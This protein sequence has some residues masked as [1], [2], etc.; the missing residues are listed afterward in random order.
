V[1]FI[2]ID[3]IMTSR[4]LEPG[5]DV[6]ELAKHI[7]NSGLQFPVLIDR[8][9]NLIDGLRRIEAHRLLGRTQIEALE[10][11]NSLELMPHLRAVKQHGHLAINHQTYERKWA[12]YQSVMSLYG[13]TRSLLTRG[14]SSNLRGRGAKFSVTSDIAEVL[15]LSNP[16]L[17][18]FV[19]LFRMRD[20]PQLNQEKVETAIAMLENGELTVH[21]ALGRMRRGLIP[22][23]HVNNL[24][25]QRQA[26][27]SISAS[28]G[29]LGHVLN[30]MGRL[31]PRLSREEVEAH[32]D[33]MRQ[34]QT[35]L[36]RFVKTYTEE[37]KNR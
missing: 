16:T 11:A 29:G 8:G 3:A 36:R 18:A 4:K 27:Q 2:N 13:A 25:E 10:I 1:T 15:D 31:N 30:Q 35:T 20:K 14:Q 19:A 7:S 37:N 17:H 21:A 22:R 28:L 6:S 23:G 5:D 33:S 9:H 24:A 32:L 26:L 12:L 34:F